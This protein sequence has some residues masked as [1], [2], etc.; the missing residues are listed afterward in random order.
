MKHLRGFNE[1]LNKEELQDFCETYLAYLLD[2]GFEVSVEGIIKKIIKTIVM[3]IIL[4]R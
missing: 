3:I 2:D 1:S 4:L